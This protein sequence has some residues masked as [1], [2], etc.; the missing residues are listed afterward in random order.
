MVIGK[1]VN[2]VYVGQT[3]RPLSSQQTQNKEC[4]LK[5]SKENK[6]V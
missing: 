1:V 2:K 3:A 6:N 5:E 4:V